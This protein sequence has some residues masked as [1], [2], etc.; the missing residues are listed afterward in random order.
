MNPGLPPT[1]EQP[2]SISRLSLADA[3]KATLYVSD[4]G[5]NEVT[6][7]AW[8]KPKTGS[9][10]RGSFSEPQG[11]CADASGNV[12]ITNT[13]GSNVLEYSGSKLVNTLLDAG[14]YPVGCS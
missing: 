8:P 6:T 3:T 1:A 5:T 12:F 14:E 11:E 4:S 13:G 10:L 2:S 7:F 9:A